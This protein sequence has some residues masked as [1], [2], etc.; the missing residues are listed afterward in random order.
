MPN[1][2]S[3]SSLCMCTILFQY[4]GMM[5]HLNQSISTQY[6]TTLIITTIRWNKET[7]I[8]QRFQ[9]NNISVN[10]YMLWQFTNYNPHYIAVNFP[11]YNSGTRIN[12]RH[13]IY[14]RVPIFRPY[15]FVYFH[16]I[17]L[18]RKTSFNKSKSLNIPWTLNTCHESSRFLP[19]LLVRFKSF[20][21]YQ[22]C[23]IYK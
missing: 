12:A 8:T 7:T 21:I 1:L 5:M 6:I 16:F 4:K 23:N 11:F 3:V 19:F 20:P 18:I 14:M 13:T 15:P 17:S 10:A 9:L 2:Y 22:L